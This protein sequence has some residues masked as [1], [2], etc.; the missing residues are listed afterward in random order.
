MLGSEM[1][2]MLTNLTQLIIRTPDPD[3]RKKLA[4]QHER[5]SSMLQSLIDKTVDAAL[6][7]YAAA[8]AA[9]KVAN[10]QAEAAKKNLDKVA[11]A[12]T[13]VADAIGKVAALVAKIAVL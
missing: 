5:L 8:A 3:T 10:Q 6:P 4:K 12:I 11:D 2:E 1:S 13:S 9:L 7:E